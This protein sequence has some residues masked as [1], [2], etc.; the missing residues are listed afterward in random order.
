MEQR[1]W[2]R[3]DAEHHWFRSRDAWF[4]AQDQSWVEPAVFVDAL[5]HEVAVGDLYS[6]LLDYCHRRGIPKLVRIS[7]ANFDVIDVP[8]GEVSSSQRFA[9][10]PVASA[11]ALSGDVT[12]CQLRGGPWTSASRRMSGEWFAHRARL[13]AALGCDVCSG[14]TYELGG[15]QYSGSPVLSI[16]EP[17]VPTRWMR[18]ESE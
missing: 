15:V 7:D 17:S 3:D 13:I 10:Q 11:C 5:L 18:A 12:V 16:T 9:V 4:I 14:R 2:L 8:T 6:R 1:N